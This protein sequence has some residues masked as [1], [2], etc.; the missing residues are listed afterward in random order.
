MEGFAG[1]ARKLLRP[2]LA[3]YGLMTSLLLGT[4]TY[5][6]VSVRSP[7]EMNLLRSGRTPYTL[8]AAVLRN[9]FELHLIN[10]H[11]ET[12]SFSVKVRAPEGVVVVLP[13]P[14]I[15]LGPL[16]SLRTPFFLTIER[17]RWHG[18]FEFEVE[19]IDRDRSGT[20]GRTLKGRFLGPPGP[21]PP[22]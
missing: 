13:Q 1:R 11:A 12:D 5:Q 18:P 16:D 21:V 2:R 15:T 7:Y 8:E 14:E 22:R 4:V 6:V 20:K 9:Q 3:L 19:L 10:K 17:A